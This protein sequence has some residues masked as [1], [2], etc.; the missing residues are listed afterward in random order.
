MPIYLTYGMRSFLCLWTLL[1]P[2]TLSAQPAPEM[3]APDTYRV[4]FTDKESSPFSTAY[5]EAFL[6]ARSIERRSRQGISIETNDLPVSPAYIDS[7]V[8]TGVTILTVSKWLN[9]LT[10]VTSDME[11]LERIM[12]YPFVAKADRVKR[13]RLPAIFLKSVENKF[14]HNE[15]HAFD[16]GIA[17]MQTEVLQGKVLHNKGFTGTGMQIAVIDDGFYLTDEL[18]AFSGLRAGGQIL[19]THDFVD[20][21]SDIFS[22]GGHGMKVLSIMGGFLP[23]IF[24]GTAPDA[25]YWLL[26]SED[27][28]SEYLVEED[29]WIAA[30][31]FADSAGADIINTSLGYARFDDPLQDHVYAD[32]DGKTAR[33]SLAAD[34]AA[35][36]GM[37]VVVSAGNQGQTDWRYISAPA[38]ADDVLAVGAIDFAGKVAEFSSRGPAADGRIKPDVMAPGKG[39]YYAGTDGSIWQGNGTSLSAPLITGLSACLWQAHPDASAMEIREAILQSASLF[40]EPDTLYGYGIPD[41]RIADILLGGMENILEGN[42]SIL[43]FPNPFRKELNVLFKD[44]ASTDLIFELIDMRGRVVWQDSFTGY[45]GQHIIRV[46]E[47]LQDIPGG[48]YHLRIVSEKFTRT[49]K[50]IRN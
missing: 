20:P 39:T 27:S 49:I 28:G 45:E 15:V 11:A 43:A 38:D 25:S 29:N 17:G 4:E 16:Y 8:A 34:L 30:A 37:L 47:N 7:I 6:S 35:S 32:M 10:F 42:S 41:F 33:V 21:S 19:G 18:D 26:R 23:G 48:L 2:L 44:P 31:E 46:F 1:A 50:I 24:V 36:K 3:T 14:L 40:T 5:P 12:D 22:E 9:A 13:G